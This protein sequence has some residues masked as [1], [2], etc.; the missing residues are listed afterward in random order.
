MKIKLKKKMKTIGLF[1]L[2]CV[3]FL[4]M[5]GCKQ[6]TVPD[7]II[8]VSNECGLAID[9]FLNGVFQFSVEYEAIGSIENLDNGEHELEARRKGSGEFVSRVT[10]SVIFN[11]IY[12][13]SVLSSARV[14]VINRY[15]ETLSI[16]GDDIY[17][18]DVVD[19]ADST[20]DNVPYGD[21]KLEAKTSD[22]TIAATTT[23]SILV[24]NIYEWTINK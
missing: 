4:G 17:L 20:M 6:V 18:G 14:K 3:F 11:R 15:G 9:V 16:Y 12:T 21:R 19:Q 5:G 7:A 2:I 1:T 22:D 8:K 23:I 10:L 13:W 24:D